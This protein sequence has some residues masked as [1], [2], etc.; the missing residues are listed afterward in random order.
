MILAAGE[1][2]RMHEPKPFLKFD[3]N[4]TFIDKIIKEYQDFG[5]KEIVVVT[6]E[7]IYEQ[8]QSD[9]NILI[10]IN[11]HLDYG[12]FY[13]I[14]LGMQELIDTDYCYIQNIDN[15]FVNQKILE[16]LYS[17]KNEGDCV[18]PY[19]QGRG[20]HPI[21][22]SK[23]IINKI[24]SIEDND[25]NLRDILKKFKS[26]KVDTDDSSILININTP[27]EFRQYFY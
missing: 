21:L 26:T 14:K 20:G 23:K 3:K 5:C 19:C 24:N 9:K 13:S 15:P 7:T 10:I 12:R 18:I 27:E 6:N 25:L 11:K 22:V 2:S 4:K 1:S 8:L 17:N 16:D